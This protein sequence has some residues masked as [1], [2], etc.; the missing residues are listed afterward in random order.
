MS[1]LDR[2]VGSKAELEYLRAVIENQEYF[3]KGELLDELDSRICFYDGEIGNI[4]P[5]HTTYHDV[6]KD[7]IEK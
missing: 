1:R 2:L 3:L 7:G 5:P 4:K 6:F